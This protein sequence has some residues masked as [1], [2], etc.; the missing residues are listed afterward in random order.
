[1]SLSR[2]LVLT[3][4]AVSAVGLVALDARLLRRTPLVPVGP[5]RSA[6]ARGR[7]SRGPLVRLAD[8]RVALSRGAGVAARGGLVRTAGRTDRPAAA[9]RHLRGDSRRRR[10]RWWP[11]GFSAVIGNCRSPTCP[12]E[13]PGAAGFEET[14]A[15]RRSPRRAAAPAFASTTQTG[16]GG[17]SVVA[18]IPLT[19]LDA[20]LSSPADDRDPGHA[21]D[22]RGARRAELVGGAGRPAAARAD[23]GDGGGDRRR[24]HVPSG[25]G[26]RRAA[27]RSGGSESPSTRCCRGSSGPSPISGRARSGCGAFSPTPLTSCARR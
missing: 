7:A 1:M 12:I 4:L 20:T 13:L 5:G 23:R 14:L 19:D 25:R 15:A 2:R 16:P 21:R 18:A 24:R 3:L 17:E 27:P 11:A 9:D 8:P 22:P 26:R 10:A 6:G